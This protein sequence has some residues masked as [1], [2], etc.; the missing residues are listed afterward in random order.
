MNNQIKVKM[1]QND[2]KKIKWYLKILRCNIKLLIIK[3][4]ILFP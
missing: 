1:L 4:N 3:I 2:L